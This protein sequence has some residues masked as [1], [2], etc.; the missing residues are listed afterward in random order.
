MKKT[1]LIGAAIAVGFSAFGQ[2]NR[3]AANHLNKAVYKGGHQIDTESFPAAGTKRLTGPSSHQS[4]LC[5]PDP[6]TT[7]PNI[8]GVGGGVT[9]FQQNCFSYVKDLNAYVWT[10]R[11]SID[12]ASV[13]AMSSGSMQSTWL[14]VTAGTWDSTII[15]YEP[16]AMN[17]GRYPSG[18]FYNP[19][20][21]T[22]LAN[23]WAVGTGPDLVGN[24]GFS[25]T[26]Y[27]SRQMTGVAA[28]DHAMPGVDLNYVSAPA[29]PFGNT[30]FMNVDMQQAGTRV[31]VSGD[32]SK[33]TTSSNVNFNT[34]YG[35]VVGIADFT[36]GGAP[37]WS[38]DSL[39]PP[40]HYSPNGN[41]FAC[42]YGDGAR[43][44]M[45]P[46]GTTGYLVFMGRLATDYMNSADSMFSPIVYKTMDG[47]VTWTGPSLPGYDWRCKHPELAKN[48]GGGIFTSAPM[49]F[50]PSIYNGIDVT[51]DGNGM[52][53][54]VTTFA[55]PYNDGAD[56]DSLI[57]NYTYRW[58][59]VN[60]HPVMW[61]LM[62]DGTTDWKTMMIDS[63]I[64]SFVGD[65]P[66]SDTTASF[67]P[68][69]NGATFLPYGARLQVS[70]STDGTKI[71]YS[72]TDSDP[73]VT[74]TPFNSQ[75][76]I[77]MKGYDITSGMTTT[78]ANVTNGIAT[79]FFH[80][81]ADQ[82][83]FDAGTSKW[84]CPSVYSLPRTQ[85]SPGVYDGIS[86]TDHIYVNCAAYG[87]SDFSATAMINNES[88]TGCAIGIQNHNNF[89]NSVANYPN[90]F[91]GSTRIVVNLNEAKT[92]N[93]NV[94][95][96]MG[97]LVYTK[98][99]NGNI[100]ENTFVFDASSLSAGVYHYTVTAGYEKVTKKMV[101][102][103]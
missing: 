57:F 26:W 73:G 17:P 95:D 18:V 71:F 98:K 14:N 79:C 82:A 62:T 12:W 86:A 97:K 19:A 54:L 76:D 74:G 75:P 13:Q 96:A 99:A 87:A 34:A 55:T 2:S 27:A 7:G 89:F 102:Q 22:S 30:L 36:A 40:F 83:Y 9:T 46:N 16:S 43:L 38:H 4:S 39:L 93:V 80:M 20:S 72:W 48:V 6:F 70:R 84:N 44:A 56:P 25:G 59:Y 15:Y 61:D 3:Q 90:P 8:F 63:L 11:R 5:T 78:S 42:S 101:I 35:T 68:I 53:H 21:N 41:G 28:T 1:L 52:L 10:H 32:C 91:N 100:G 47:G 24:G 67:N 103:K 58:D 45:G 81:M 31:L 94:Y 60:Y 49:H 92:I 51:C 65:D 85:P 29:L 64:T 37:V 88:T 50:Q 23:V 69:Q 66:A 33:D 77:F